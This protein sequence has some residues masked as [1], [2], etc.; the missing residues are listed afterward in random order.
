MT[1]F[2]ANSKDLKTALGIACLATGQGDNLS[3]H[4][5]FKIGQNL[6]IFSTDRDRIS[7]SECPI[8]ASGV[9]P[10][11]FTSDPKK[12]TALINSSNS[13]VINFD[14]KPEEKTLN[15]YAS[16][17]SS[18]YLSFP[19]LDTDDFNVF[20][21]NATDFD[22]IKVVDSGILLA[23]ISFVQGFI[24]DDNKDK[25]FSRLYIENGVFYGSNGS[26]KVGAFSSPDFD[27]LNSIIIRKPMLGPLVNMINLTDTKDITIQDNDKFLYFSTDGFGFGFLKVIEE[28][29]NFPIEMEAP[30]C[31]AFK[32]DKNVFLKKINRLAIMGDNQIG[33][34]A[35][36]SN[37]SSELSTLDERP[38]VELMDIVRISGTESFEFFFKHKLM[39]STLKQ[40]QSSDVDLYVKPKEFR[41]LARSEG[42]MEINKGVIKKFKSLGLVGLATVDDK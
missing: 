30:N 22:T 18:S 34:K 4:A 3:G 10:I 36:I 26:N 23:A 37:N 35:H 7:I 25:K 38:S 31:D 20:L 2:T 1:S 41:L 6:K 12:L 28:M 29:I 32:I 17:N 13:E 24:S 9:E 39:M 42:D 16:E 21:S 19:S 33:I 40:F 5:L 15:V 11:D 14:Y 27:G 8:Q